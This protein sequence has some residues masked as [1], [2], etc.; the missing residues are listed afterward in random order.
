MNTAARFALEAWSV[1]ALHALAASRVPD[2]LASR[3]VEGALPPPFVASRSLAQWQQ[4]QAPVWY[5]TYGIVSVADGRLVGSCGFKH[6][7]RNACVEIGYGVAPACQGLGAASAAVRLLLRLA[8]AQPGVDEV[9]ARV[10]R[11]NLAST[12]VVCKLGF[13]P[14]LEQPDEDGELLVPWR[15]CRL[16]TGS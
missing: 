4:G 2:E 9:L 16:R 11:A 3:V 6:E 10:N 15:S 13:E 7:P 8:F 12:R 1:E 14:G 5:S